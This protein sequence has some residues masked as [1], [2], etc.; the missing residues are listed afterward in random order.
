ML[1]CRFKAAYGGRAGGKSHC[2]A[3]LLLARIILQPDLQAVVIRRFRQSL[4]NSAQ[5][6]LKNKI[7]DLGFEDYFEIQSN[8][9][10]RRDG[11]G[12]VAFQ[13]M[14]DHNA[15]SIKSFENFGIAWVEEANE[16]DQRSLDLL[17]PTIRS[18]GAEC[19][20]SWN[21]D[22]PSDP[23]DSFFRGAAPPKNAIIRRVSFSDNPFLS[24][25]SRD[26]E[27]RALEADP[28]KHAW[29]WLG[30][31]NLKSDSII[32]SGRW[33]TGIIEPVGWDGPYYGADWGFANDPTCAIEVW[34]SGNQIYVSKESYAYRLLVADTARRWRRDIPGIE[35]RVVRADSSRPDSIT[36]LRRDG[37][38][39]ILGAEKYP[40]SVEDGIEWLRS[41]EIIVNPDCKET[42]GE[43]KRYR[44]KTNQGGDVLA[45]IHDADNH[46]ID[47]IR[48]ALL[49]LIRARYSKF[50]QGAARYG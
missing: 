47:S 24:D 40:G 46:L 42:Q 32:F 33:R 14:Q 29:V 39:Q 18:E 31:Y 4:T 50:G 26:D 15:S 35:S 41:H 44:Y 9:I 20:F 2:L 6:L 3:E 10:L 19:W 45:A 37:F 1:P 13:G 7:I 22:Q 12:F 43:L 21:P 38:S 23:V 17:I 36:Q 8:R 11:R 34:C 16:L 27:Q 48:Y 25:T 30:E 49:P 28:E 5:L